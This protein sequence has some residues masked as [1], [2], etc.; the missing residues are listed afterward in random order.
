MGQ[1]SSIGEVLE[2]AIVREMQAVN[3][4]AAMA[5]RIEDQGVKSVLERLAE[6]EFEHKRRLELEM[7]KEGIVAKAVDKLIEV[8]EAD[9][10]RE[11]QLDPDAELA[12]VLSVAIE[13]ERRAFRFYAD[14]AGIMPEADVHE[15]ILGLA[16]EEVRHLIW[17]EREYRKMVAAG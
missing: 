12:G 6:A 15:V 11:M 4:Y 3:F 16:E 8:E 10:A 5:G 2:L 17:I 7:M 14:L 9:Y 13:K 1:V